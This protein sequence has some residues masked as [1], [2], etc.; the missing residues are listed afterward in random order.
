MP[1]VKVTSEE[2]EALD[3]FLSTNS[4]IGENITYYVNYS[5]SFSNAYKPLKDMGLEKFVKCLMD[6][7]ELEMPPSPK[8]F[9]NGIDISYNKTDNDLLNFPGREIYINAPNKGMDIEETKEVCKA[10]NELINHYET[11][12]KPNVKY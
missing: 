3:T 12:V 9:R 2:K 1:K 11:Y 5:K 7:Y 4:N 6:G 10:L 8:Y